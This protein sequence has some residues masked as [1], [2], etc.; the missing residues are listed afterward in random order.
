MLRFRG[1]DRERSSTSESPSPASGAFRGGRIVR[2][3]RFWLVSCF[4]LGALWH[5]WLISACFG[6]LWLV[7]AHFC[8]FL[9]SGGVL[10][11]D[12]PSMAAYWYC[13]ERP[14]PSRGVLP[15]SKQQA[16]RALSSRLH[17]A[18]RV[19]LSPAPGAHRRPSAESRVLRDGPP[20]LE[21]TT[22]KETIA[23]RTAER[24]LN[25]YSRGGQNHPVVS[26]PRAFQNALGRGVQPC[27]LQERL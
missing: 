26:C 14:S 6:S 22:K 15:N 1:G 21:N 3:C 20:A 5:F 23:R 25:Q 11:L 18:S 9:L 13:L 16:R 19:P 7:F 24:V 12:T 8:S 10:V 4:F 2:A 27:V 17:L